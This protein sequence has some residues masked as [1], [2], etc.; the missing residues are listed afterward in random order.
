[1]PLVRFIKGALQ[2][3]LKDNSFMLLTG[4]HN[5]VAVS[6]MPTW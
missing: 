2:I 3:I 4:T 6:V 1:M 5:F